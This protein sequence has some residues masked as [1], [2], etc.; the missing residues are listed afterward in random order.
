MYPV[1]SLP[2]DRN[3]G[4]TL[5]ELVAII[6]L[7]S[8]LGV[9]ALGKLNIGGFDERGYTDELTSAIRYAQK[10]AVA[11]NCAVRMTIDNSGYRLMQPASTS[12]CTSSATF[13][14]DVPNPAGGSMFSAVKPDGVSATVVTFYFY[15][16]GN[17]DSDLDITVSGE[18]TRHICVVD[19]SGYVYQQT[20]AC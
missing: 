13:N 5:I 16:L 20:A 19:A 17:T 10:Y 3:L 12:N 8:I 9:V 2:A 6:I 4:F 18:S 7:L 14:V 1:T 11:S 15:G